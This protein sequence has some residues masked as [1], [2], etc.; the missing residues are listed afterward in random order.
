M[1]VIAGSC[2]REL[3]GAEVP[4]FSVVHGVV[5][6][7]CP[8]ASSKLEGAGSESRLVSLAGVERPEL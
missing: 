2:S 3:V 4:A 6:D 5:L 7:H 8:R 1:N